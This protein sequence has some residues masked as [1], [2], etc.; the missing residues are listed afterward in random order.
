[1]EKE[2]LGRGFHQQEARFR[3]VDWL[4]LGSSFA[5][6]PDQH[7]DGQEQRVTINST[8]AKHRNEICFI[9]DDLV[10]FSASQRILASSS[11]S[12]D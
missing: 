4:N 10:A 2:F 9:M 1:M 12:K 3:A 11:L 6:R 5:S 8:G 7:S